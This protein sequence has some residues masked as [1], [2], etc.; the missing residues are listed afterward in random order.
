[1]GGWVR[2]RGPL[3]LRQEVKPPSTAAGSPLA[4]PLVD[5]SPLLDPAASAASVAAVGARL[6][7]AATDSGFLYVTGHGVDPALMARV[8]DGVRTFFFA[9][10]QDEKEQISIRRDPGSG[11][12]YQRLMDNGAGRGTWARVWGWGESGMSAGS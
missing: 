7:A 11:R 4:L 5:L 8:L 12:G 2:V 1:V 3:Q 6:T 9:T 10:P